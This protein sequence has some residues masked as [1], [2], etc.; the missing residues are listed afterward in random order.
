M[1][2]PVSI[3]SVYVTVCRFTKRSVILLPVSDALDANQCLQGKISQLVSVTRLI[4][5]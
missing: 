1:G 5:R 4:A 3:L 2:H